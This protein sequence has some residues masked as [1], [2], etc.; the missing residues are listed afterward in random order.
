MLKSGFLF[1]NIRGLYPKT[2][3]TKVDY[4]SDTALIEG[5]NI[6]CLTESHLSDEIKDCEVKLLG[7]DI[8]KQKQLHYNYT[9]I[10][11]WANITHDT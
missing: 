8:H 2:N 6:V 3:R 7:Y 10:R 5:T 11:S 9:I 4:L 1:G